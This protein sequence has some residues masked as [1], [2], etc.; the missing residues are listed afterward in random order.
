VAHISQHETD[1]SD[2]EAA[3]EVGR[4]LDPEAV[5]AD[6]PVV[7]LID[8]ANQCWLDE[9]GFSRPPITER[10][11]EELDEFIDRVNVEDD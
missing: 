8:E 11:D 7:D 1:A 4:I 9:P 10:S 2:G 5:P 6:A 3:D